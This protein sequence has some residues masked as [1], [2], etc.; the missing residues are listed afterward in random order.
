M[1]ELGFALPDELRDTSL[2][3]TVDFAQMAERQGFDSVWKGE[4][5]G[6]NGLMVLSAVAQQTDRVRLGTGIAN[7]YSRSPALLGM[8]SVTL[9][10]LSGGRAVLGIGVSAP[11]LVED[12][13]DMAYDRPLRRTREAMEIIRQCY[14][15]GTVE[16]EGEIFDVGPYTMELASSRSSIPILNAAMGPTNRKLTGEFA[17]GWLPVFVPISLLPEYTEGV[18]DA[19]ANRGRDPDEIKMVPWVVTAVS[20]DKQRATRLA[21]EHLAHEMGVGYDRLAADYGF[22]AA[23]RKAAALWREGDREAAAAAISS[24]MVDELSISGTPEDCRAQLTDFSEAGADEVVLLPPF[25]AT[26]DERV[27]LLKTLGPSGEQHA[28]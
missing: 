15:G 1:L 26:D 13:H 16:Y 25:S 22:E 28:D 3:R 18:T 20:E 6:S 23:A 27:H 14:E 4:T 9:D 2:S 17:D 10:E 11:P 12:W 5:S 24:E 7:V 8:S 19:A 21:R